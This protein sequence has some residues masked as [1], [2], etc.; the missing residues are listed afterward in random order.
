MVLWLAV[1]ATTMSSVGSDPFAFMLPATGLEAADRAR[2]DAGDTLIKVLPVENP[3]LAVF[4]ATRIEID[5]NRLVA[6]VRQVQDLYKGSYMPMIGRFSLTPHIEDLAGLVVDDQDLEDIRR[7]RPGDCGVKLSARE[8]ETLQQAI[9]AAGAEWKPAAQAAFR[10]V[11]LVRAQHFLAHGYCENEVYDDHETPV[12]PEAEFIALTRRFVPVS[13][14]LGALA[15]YLMRRPRLEERDVESFLYWSKD[16]L[17]RK[18]TISVTHLSIV[19][20]ED[21]GLPEAFVIA[22]QVFASHY[23]T[24]AFGIIAITRAAPGRPRYL[25]YLNRS[26]VDVLDGRLASFVRHVIERRIRAEAPA[27]LQALRRRLEGGE[28]PR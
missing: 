20:S 5:A 13:R 10:R 12:Q 22:R 4:G 14:A 6:W 21:P 26:R 18:A 24:G 17:G 1:G 8:I 11:V 7:C 3:E 25:L 9:A 16:T 28:P 2:L 27:S 15:P 19:R 23:V